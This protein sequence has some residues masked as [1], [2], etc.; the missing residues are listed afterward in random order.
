MPYGDQAI[1]LTA[2]TFRQV[3]G[4]VEMPIMEDFELIRRLQR[5]GRIEILAA[6]VITSSRRWLQRGVWQTTLINQAIVLGYSIG[7]SPARLAKW[8]HR[9]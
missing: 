7:I 6:P 2:E 1:F 9:R 3:G 5:R 4:F 8:Y